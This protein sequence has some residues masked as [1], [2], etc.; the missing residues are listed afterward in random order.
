MKRW[1]NGI[2]GGALAVLM[3]SGTGLM[4]SED[5][6]LYGEAAVSE[7]ETYTVEEMLLYAIEDEYMAEASY[8]AIMDAYGTVKPF[9]SIAKAEG[10]HIS[11]LLPLFETYGFEVP[12]NEAADRIE[13]PASLAESFEAGVEGEINN[14]AVYGQFLEAEDLPDDVRSVF[15]RLMAA[16]ENHLA[17]FERGVA[18]NPDGAG[19]KR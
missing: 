1:R 17:A 15:E 4:A 12:E 3:F 13:L 10:T 7:G 18:G 9:T 14:I 19:R 6:E 16:S 8:I 11:L 5:E 2:V